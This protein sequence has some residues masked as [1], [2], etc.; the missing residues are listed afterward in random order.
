MIRIR[1]RGK[2]KVKAE[3]KVTVS[4]RV[5]DPI[6]PLWSHADLDLNGLPSKLMY[7]MMKTVN[8]MLGLNDLPS[9]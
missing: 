1:V 9:T 4:V 3:V 5:K 2:V 8:S 6:H 7:R